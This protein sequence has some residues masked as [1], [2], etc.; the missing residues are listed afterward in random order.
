M[1]A[2]A[3]AVRG[4]E[5]EIAMTRLMLHREARDGTPTDYARLAD[6]L[7]KLVLL[8]QQLRGDGQGL[9]GALARLLDEVAADLGIGESA[10][11]GSE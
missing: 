3:R 5:E 7:K 4:V 6:A 1:L 8:E 9:A 11:V 2:L 10:V